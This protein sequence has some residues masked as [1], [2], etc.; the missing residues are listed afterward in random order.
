[1]IAARSQNGIIGKDQTMPWHVSGDLKFFKKTTSGKPVIMGR[2]TFEGLKEKFG[3]GLPNRTNIIL[4]RDKDYKS[5]GITACQDLKS[6]I[7]T[8]K[9]SALKDNKDE[10]FIIG[11]GEVYKLGLEFADKI[12]LTEININV[13]G[14]TYFPEIDKTIWKIEN[15]ER[16]G[17]GEKDTADYMINTWVKK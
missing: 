12:Y 5:D 14:D 8:A 1:M 10:I 4:T 2:K 9:K 6:C 16:F 15:S 17:K 13:E 11:G 7:E 3:G